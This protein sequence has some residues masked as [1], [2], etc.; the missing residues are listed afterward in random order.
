MSRTF[1]CVDCPLFPGTHRLQTSKHAEHQ[2][3]IQQFLESQIP[4]DDLANDVARL[5]VSQDNNEVSN[6]LDDLANVF[7]ALIVADDGPNVATQQ[8]SKLFSSRGDFQA[9]RPDVPTAPLPMSTLDA[10]RSVQTLATQ[11]RKVLPTKSQ[12]KVATLDEILQRVLAAKA[13]LDLVDAMYAG[14]QVEAA[15]RALDS[16]V[17]TVV[18]AG[19]ALQSVKSAKKEKILGKLWDE[20]Q[21]EA[22]ALNQLIDCVGAILPGLDEPEYPLEY[23]AEHHYEDPV[24]TLD[25]LAQIVL[26]FT[27]IINVIIGL[28]TDACNF[29]LDTVVMIVKLA[30]DVSSPG[31]QSM[32]NENQIHVLSQI[33]TSLEDALKTFKLEPKTRILATCPSCHYTHE[34][35]VDR[36]T[37]DTAQQCPAGN[38]YSSSGSTNSGPSNLSSSPTLLTTWP[39]FSQTL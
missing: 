15:H 29:L 13:S 17:E 24:H 28:S 19:K 4:L 30:M 27:V 31:P 7:T 12:R 1:R 20:V 32:F 10:V 39:P 26:L 9:S 21:A 37:G 35:K 34:P 16:A 36:L 18:A 23:D 14:L 33:P 25:S 8:H 2:L 3:E 22:R 5:T 38:L 6:N 11:P